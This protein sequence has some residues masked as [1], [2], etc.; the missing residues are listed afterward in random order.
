MAHSKADILWKTQEEIDQE[1]K[2][3]EEQ[4]KLP[5]TEEKLAKAEQELALTQATMDN[6]LTE[7]IPSLFM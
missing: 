1:I 6:L 3:A 7:V 2:E 5:T 4:S